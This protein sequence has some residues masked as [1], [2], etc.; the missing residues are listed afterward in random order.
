MKACICRDVS[1]HTV[2]QVLADFFK[3]IIVHTKR[4]GDGPEQ[5]QQ[6]NNL[7]DLHEACSG[8]G[9]KCGKCACYMAELATEHNHNVR[10]NELRQNLPA[11]LPS[12]VQEPAPAQARNPEKLAARPKMTI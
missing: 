2:K 9:F 6:D 7:D 3:G 11:P 1:D 4:R 8:D 10:M 5:T 12:Q